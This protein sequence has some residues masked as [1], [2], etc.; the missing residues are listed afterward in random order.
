A[1]LSAGTPWTVSKI[2]YIHQPIRITLPMVRLAGQLEK[3]YRAAAGILPNR[4]RTP[5][6]RPRLRAGS[7]RFDIWAL[8]LVEVLLRLPLRRSNRSRRMLTEI[9]CSDYFDTRD[10]AL[11]AHATQIDPKG[12]LFVIP[13]QWKQRLWPT[14]KFQLAK[15][16]VATSVSESDL[17]SGITS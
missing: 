1:Y 3:L 8:R 5:W 6:A 13:L 16:R 9:S 11:R 7:H 4:L 15:T 10:D 12:L 2:Y 14:E 17:F